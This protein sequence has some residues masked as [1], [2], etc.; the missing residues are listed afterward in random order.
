MNAI[1]V[2]EYGDSEVVEPVESERPEPGPGEVRIAVEAAGLNFADVMQRRGDYLGGPEPPFVP[3]M[4]AAGAVDVVGEGVEYEVGDRVVAMLGGG[5]YAEYALA[6]AESLFPLPDG[7]STTEAAGMPVQYLT[8]HACLFEWGGLEGGERVLIQAAAGGVGTAAVQLAS[9]V[10]A[11][12]FGTASTPEKLALAERLGCDHPIRYTEEA[13]DEVVM[14]ETDGEGVDLVLESVGGETFSRSLDALS[15]MGRL[16]AFGAASGEPGTIDSVRLL[17]ETKS[18]L[19]F[20][21]GTSMRHAP[22]RVLSALPDLTEGFASGELRVVLG[23]SF[24]LSE[25]ADAHA[26]VESRRSSGKVLLIP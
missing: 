11:E 8:A 12:V 16:V 24:A 2:T 25:A 19:G 21:L 23:E 5:G 15:P 20:H 4:E 6:D 7:M 14:E 17:F 18:V 1:E 9:R 13:F 26:H 3:G 10:G 22:D